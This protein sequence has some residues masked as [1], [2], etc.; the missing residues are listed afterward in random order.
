MQSDQ[1]PNNGLGCLESFKRVRSDRRTA[2]TVHNYEYVY[3]DGVDPDL[4]VRTALGIALARARAYGN[5][6]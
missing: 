6:A 3:R 1:R 4:A 5:R 2:L